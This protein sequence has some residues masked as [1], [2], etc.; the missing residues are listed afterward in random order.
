MSNIHICPLSALERT[1]QTSR[2]TWMVSL[3]GPGKS[4]ERPK[5]IVSGFLALEF[6][7]INEPQDGL[8]APSRNHISKLLE[9]LTSWGGREPLLM[10]C[11]MGIS[12]STAAAAI[13]LA[14]IQPNRN[15]TDLA[16]Q[17]RQASPMASPNALMINHA[18]TLLNLNGRLS[19]AIRGIGRGEEAFEG[20][21]FSLPVT[22]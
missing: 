16:S 9:F 11:W 5:Q 4:P 6:N 8:L 10:H 20:V 14:Q 1:L 21:P 15:M 19:T 7:D 22:P 18:D 12:R 2:A 3:S 13:A 17:I